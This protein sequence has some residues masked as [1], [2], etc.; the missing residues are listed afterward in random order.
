[1][2]LLTGGSAFR[3]AAAIGTERARSSRIR[4]HYRSQGRPRH[5]QLPPGA[6]RVLRFPGIEPST[7]PRPWATTPTWI[8]SPPCNGCG[9]PDNVTIF[10]FSAGGLSVHSLLA[11]RLARGLFHK[12]IVQSG[13]S[14]DSV[15]TARPMREGGVDPNYPV[16]A[17][18][19][20]INFARSMG[21][22]GTDAAL[23]RLRAGLP[24]WPRHDP[25]NDVILDFRP[26]GSAS[27][28][29]DLRKARL[30]VTQLN[31]EAGSDPTLKSEAC[32][33]S[34]LRSAVPVND[35]IN[36]FGTVDQRRWTGAGRSSRRARV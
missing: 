13:G 23:G 35:R 26:N 31:T 11:S 6:L 4:Q 2:S 25:K 28:G 15:L 10:G 5:G 30:D 8:R 19:L 3:T 20:G 17:E 27:A 34:I 33:S 24:I 14:R 21:I 32:G 18:T 29:P 9:D 22:D 7:L 12:A 16:S 1:M 36:A